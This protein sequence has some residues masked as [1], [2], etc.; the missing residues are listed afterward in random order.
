MPS[1]TP[2][3]IWIA[4]RDSLLC[5]FMSTI[6]QH[7]YIDGGKF[8]D[9]VS[10]SVLNSITLRDAVRSM[11]GVISEEKIELLRV[12]YRSYKYRK[13]KEKKTLQIE[14]S[15]HK[16]IMSA[17]QEH[18]FDTVDEALYHLL[19]PNYSQQREWK[20]E[21]IQVANNSI[22]GDKNYI[23][24]LLERLTA[25]DKKMVLLSIE[26]AFMDG[27]KEAKASKTKKVSAL[28]E[29]TENYINQFKDSKFL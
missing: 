18:Y 15:T 16:W 29:S 23:Y 14:G 11:R 12:R 24:S 10:N 19:N 20:E 28:A 3:P 21:R 2:D 6:D 13:S 17:K 22:E 1:T 26:R 7:D 27:W 4:Y 5:A 25:N 9:D 8:A